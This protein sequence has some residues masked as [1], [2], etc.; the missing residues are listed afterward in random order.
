MQPETDTIPQA[1]DEMLSRAGIDI[2][3]ASAEIAEL[4]QRLHTLALQMAATTPMD[5]VDAAALIVDQ[6]TRYAFSKA[7][8]EEEVQ[9]TMARLSSHKDLDAW[10]REVRSGIPWRVAPRV[11]NKYADGRPPGKR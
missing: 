2:Q 7:T 9:R 6:L 4:K 1:L 10:L 5:Y 8:P 11:R 3:A